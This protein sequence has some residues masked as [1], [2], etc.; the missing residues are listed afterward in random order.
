MSNIGKKIKI[1]GNNIVKNNNNISV[2]RQP[3]NHKTNNSNISF[4]YLKR[5]KPITPS[6]NQ[7]ERNILLVQR[8]N[9]IAGYC[10]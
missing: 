1:A 8:S 3:S 7:R 9:G 4:N 6:I 10:L 5:K 2:K